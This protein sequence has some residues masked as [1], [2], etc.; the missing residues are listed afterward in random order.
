MLSRYLF[1]DQGFRGNTKNYYEVENSYLNRVI[2]RRTGIP[3][4]LSILYLLVGR[5][6]GLPLYGIGMPGH[7][8]VKFDSERYKVFVDCFNAGA[9]LTEKDCARFL[10]QAGYGFEEK[11]LQKSST[12]A[13]LTRS[14][15]NLIAVYN[16]LNESVKASRFSRFIEILDGAKKG[17]CGTGA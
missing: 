8:L 16:K 15:K 2:D 9:L 5:R 6:L 17:E 10:M 13:I 14:L 3:I 4:S 12:P 11:Y 1:I 7:F